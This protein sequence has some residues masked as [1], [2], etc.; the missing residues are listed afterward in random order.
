MSLPV[1]LMRGG[2]S[3]GAVIEDAV[4]PP[5]GAL[6]DKI[7]QE[8]FG[9]PDR[10]QIDGIGGATPLTSKVMVIS[11]SSGD[12]D[13]RYE[14]GQVGIADDRILWVGNCGNMSA[15]VAVAAVERGWVSIG[16]PVTTVRMFSVNDQASVTARVE[17]PSGLLPSRGTQMIS[18]VPKAGIGV[19]LDYPFARGSLKRGLFPT[20]SPKDVVQIGNDSIEVSIV[21]YAV[22][23]V[24]VSNV[25]LG[26][27]ETDLRDPDQMKQSVMEKVQAIRAACAVLLGVARSPEEAMIVSPTIPR[28][29]VAT[30]YT[31]KGGRASVSACQVAG[32]GFH[33]AYPV[34]GGMSLSA[35]TRRESVL[36]RGIGPPGDEWTVAVSHPSGIAEFLVAARGQAVESI[37]VMRSARVIVRGEAYVTSW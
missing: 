4:L 18:G 20:G 28:I 11:P 13:V 32:D 14:F 3:K 7:I 1:L 35:L 37:G 6:R 36:G 17:T 24:I 5:R 10:R 31:L 19:R 25:S 26:I 29:A 12:F 2:T 8:L 27:S 23:V 34:T 9:S 22:P 33:E 16:D 15:A 21:D 30:E